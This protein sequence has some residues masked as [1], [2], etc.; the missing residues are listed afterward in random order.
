V[1]RDEAGLKATIAALLPLAVGHGPACDPALVGLMIAVAALQRQE[2]R[3]AHWRTD[4]PM[5][6]APAKRSL[7]RF[8]DA[9][10]AAG[11]LGADRNLIARSA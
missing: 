9:V 2:S 1:L 5:R 6:S 8:A 3:G 11:E 4:F 7:L 10:A